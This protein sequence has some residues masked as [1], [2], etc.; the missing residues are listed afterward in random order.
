MQ[1]RPYVLALALV[2]SIPAAALAGGLTFSDPSGDDFGPGTYT[3][4][5]DGVYKRGSFD[6]RKVEILDKGS[7]VEFAVTIAAPIDDPWDSKSWPEPGHGFSLQMVQVYIDTDHKAGS[8]FTDA[9]P[10]INATF[11]AADAWDRVVLI[12]PQAKSRIRSEV[13]AKAAPMKAAVVVPTKTTPSGSRIVVLVDK[14][15]LGTAPMSS[16]GVQVVMQSNEGYPD[17]RDILS[18]KVNEFEGQHR[19][20]GGSDYECDPHAID[21]LVAPA[22]GGADEAAGQKKAL[23]Y[24]CGPDGQSVQPAVLPML[25]LG[26]Q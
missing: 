21:I 23:A 8:G 14:R 16:W 1:L 12:S 20:G 2:A 5:T 19:F 11:A 22:K 18:R 24:R 15:D 17:G 7:K 4:P 10:G 3:Y 6:L 26:Q 13:A 25:R 9:L